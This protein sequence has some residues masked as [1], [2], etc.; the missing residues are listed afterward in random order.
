MK[1]FAFVLFLAVLFTPAHAQTLTNINKLDE[2]LRSVGE[3]DQ[4]IR[5]ELIEAVAKAQETGDINRLDSLLIQMKVIDKEN[6]AF[7]ESVLDSAGWVAGLSN[8][9]NSAIFLVIDHA[10]LDFQK[11]YIDLVKAQSEAKVI[12]ASQYVTLLDRVLMKSGKPQQYGTQTVSV[13]NETFLWTVSDPDNLNRRRAEVGL[14]PI[15]DYL[16]LV[17]KTYGNKVVWDKSKTVE[18][19]GMTFD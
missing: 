12:S 11:K 10:N 2:E 3:K 8:E 5:M 13:N 19:F 6:Q 1:K 9:A 18:S 15:E 14:M 4:S 7:V 16:L 17:E